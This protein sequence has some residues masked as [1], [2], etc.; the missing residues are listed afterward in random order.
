M[1][2][3]LLDEF[4]VEDSGST[5]PKYDLENRLISFA[6]ATIQMCNSFPQEYALVHLAKQLIRSSTSFALNYGELQAA[7]SRNDFTH[8]MKLSLKELRESSINLK[9]IERLNHTK[10]DQVVLQSLKDES[11]QLIS[12]F[13]SSL[14]TLSKNTT[15]KNS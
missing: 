3:I 6:A 13:V 5:Y 8:K 4:L 15:S 2:E 14:K 12:I 9:I 7:E 11:N 10:I 1:N